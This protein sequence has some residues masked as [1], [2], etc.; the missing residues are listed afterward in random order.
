MVTEFSIHVIKLRIKSKL[1]GYFSNNLR[2]PSVYL[3]KDDQLIS[4]PINH[5]WG[6][7]EITISSPSTRKIFD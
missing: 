4:M 5:K 1:D 3:V 6:P 7:D 2:L